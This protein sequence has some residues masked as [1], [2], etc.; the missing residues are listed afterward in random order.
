MPQVHVG[1]A[2]LYSFVATLRSNGVDTV[3]SDVATADSGNA[4]TLRVTMN[5]ADNRQFAAVGV[6]PTPGVNANVRVAG[7]LFQSLI[8]VI[9]AAVDGPPPDEVI[10][11]LTFIAEVDVP[12]WA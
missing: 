1:K 8:E 10:L 9:P 12:S 2:L 11:T 3:I 4:D 7:K 6:V 5:P